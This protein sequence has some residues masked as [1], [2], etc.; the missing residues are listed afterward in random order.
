MRE[1]KDNELEKV[2]GG[3]LSKQ[4]DGWINRNYDTIMARAAEKGLTYL[5]NYAFKTVTDDPTTE[6]SLEEIKNTLRN[7]IKIDDLT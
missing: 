5:A 1:I 3:Y 7:F 2:L 4:A 6:Y